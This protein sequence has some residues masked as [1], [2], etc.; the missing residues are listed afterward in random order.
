[1]IFLLMR[2]R[3]QVLKISFDSLYH[4]EMLCHPEQELYQ[5]AIVSRVDPDIKAH[6]FLS[7]Q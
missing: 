2:E 5:H 3:D 6:L 7:N 1:M 4:N